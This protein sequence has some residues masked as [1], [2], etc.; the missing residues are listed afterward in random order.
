MSEKKLVLAY[1]IGTTGNKTCLYEIGGGMRLIGQA[2]GKYALHLSDGGFAEQAPE[3]WWQSL[4]ATTRAVL[5][6]TGVAPARIEA[7]SFCSQMQCVVLVDRAGNALRPA[8]SYMDKRATKEF[9][10]LARAPS[11]LR[12]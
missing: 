7:V 12:G 3:D 6:R 10:A 11:P 5:E 9:A 2:S 8:M 1:D 4:A